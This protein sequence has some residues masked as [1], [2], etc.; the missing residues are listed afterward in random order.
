MSR[1]WQAGDLVQQ[2]GEWRLLTTRDA[3]R[4]NEPHTI[5]G[6]TLPS[7]LIVPA[8]AV[9]WDNDNEKVFTL[10]AERKERREQKGE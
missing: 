6:V 7:G 2:F 1:A 9:D 10:A 3:K 8:K 5:N 4:L